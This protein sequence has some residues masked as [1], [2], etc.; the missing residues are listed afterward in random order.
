MIEFYN[1]DCLDAMREYPDKAFDLAIVDP[2]YGGHDAIN[3]K[4]NVSGYQA[5]KRRQYHSFENVV[6]GQDYFDELFRVS[7]NQIVW[8]A[9]FFDVRGLRGGVYLLGQE[10]N[11]IR[12][13]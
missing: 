1:R 6:P 13:S 8:G 7:K 4:D 5:A 9:N 11:C 3:I 2:P 12:Q 10:R